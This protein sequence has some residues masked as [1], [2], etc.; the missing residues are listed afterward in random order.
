[1]KKIS[2]II[3]ALT[4]T[5]I[6]FAQPGALDSTFGGDGIVTLYK[7]FKQENVQDMAL[8][9]D[10]KILILTANDGT[11]YFKKF[12]PDGTPD[13]SFGQSG[14]LECYLFGGDVSPFTF[15]IDSLNRIVLVGSTPFEG[16]WLARLLEDG[17]VENSF[18]GNEANLDFISDAILIQTDGKI[19]IA[20]QYLGVGRVKRY[21]EDGSNDLTF[22]ST[23]KIDLQTLDTSFPFGLA[24]Q[25]DG[26]IIVTGTYQNDLFVARINTNGTLDNTFAGLGYEVL[27]NED[28]EA[29]QEVAILPDGKIIISGYSKTST[30]S[31]TL[32][33]RFLTD[34]S[35]DGSFGSTGISTLYSGSKK[36]YA[37]S[38]LPQADT[39]AIVVASIYAEGD[40]YHPGVFHVLNNGNLDQ[41]FGENGIAMADYKLGTTTRIIGAKTPEGNILL[42]GTVFDNGDNMAILSQIDL[43]GVIDS[44]FGVSGNVIV[45][46]DTAWGSFGDDAD[47]NAMANGNVLCT[48]TPWANQDLFL[49]QLLDDGSI[50]SS[51]GQ[52]GFLIFNNHDYTWGV[53]MTSDSNYVYLAKSYSDI[54]YN[55]HEDLT[56]DSTSAKIRIYRFN[57]DGVLDSSYGKMGISEPLFGN[58]YIGLLHNITIQSDGKLLVAGVQPITGYFWDI[59]NHPFLFRLNVDGSIDSSFGNNGLDLFEWENGENAAVAVSDDNK[60]IFESSHYDTV[61]LTTMIRIIS[62]KQD[63]LVDTTFGNNGFVDL[64]AENIYG[65][66]W[67][68]DKVI[69]VLGNY[70]NAVFEDFLMRHNGDGNIDSSFGT[71]GKV[72]FDIQSGF[73]SDLIPTAM[74]LPDGKIVAYFGSSPP[75]K[76]FNYD[77]SIDLTFG[78]F[79]VAIVPIIS[80]ANLDLSWDNKIL[81]TGGDIPNFFIFRLLNDIST[82]SSSIDQV[83]T[84]KIFPNPTSDQLVINYPFSSNEQAVITITDLSGKVLQEEKGNYSGDYYLINLKDFPAGIYLLAL[85]TKSESISVKVMKD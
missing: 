60:I 65:C 27:E 23:G 76:R 62:L 11:A 58:N 78:N 31:N 29:G 71:N 34:G 85:K 38:V 49:F 70:D 42:C 10:G 4:I 61:L 15:V 54:F 12:L 1:M 50:D 43:A 79:G 19:V 37:W 53:S 81:V 80:R 41:D 73:S 35:L 36:N 47:C 67:M 69:S 64:L 75:M 82:S 57:Q 56:S 24:Q 63:G 40:D 52:D 45:A 55:Y 72:S 8:T 59:P 26:K 9:K 51:Y 17:T 84:L 6:A 21:N 39:T 77:G 20:G 30:T 13:S 14:I 33:W 74:S 22:N 7:S 5:S 18:M 68:N 28:T 46:T 3:V 48:V 66:F 16:P 2:T 32:C 25:S 83:S 44:A